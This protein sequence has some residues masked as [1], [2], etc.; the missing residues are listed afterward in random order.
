MMASCANGSSFPNRMT[1]NDQRFLL[2]L[3]EHAETV[4]ALIEGD[5]FGTKNGSVELHFDQDG[6]LRKVM[7]H[8]LTLVR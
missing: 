1:E 5:V 6:R 7:K 8:Q 2:L 4:I 3:G